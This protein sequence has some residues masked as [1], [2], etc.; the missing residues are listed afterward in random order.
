MPTPTG[1]ARGVT[2]YDIA[3]RT[4]PEVVGSAIWIQTT[5]GAN[6]IDGLQHDWP[7]PRPPGRPVQ[8]DTPA[9]PPAVLA[10]PAQFA[11]TDWPMPSAPPRQPAGVQPSV[12]PPVPPAAPPVVPS[13]QPNPQRRPRRPQLDA[14]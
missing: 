1:S 2:S 14:A 12:T 6:T 10:P 7:T 4:Q 13:Q 9:P 3:A 8:S 5:P 11:P